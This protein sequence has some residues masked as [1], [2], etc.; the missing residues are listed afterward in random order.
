MIVCQKRRI[1]DRVR[2]VQGLDR[3]KEGT[4][5][6]KRL[7]PTDGRGIPQLGKGHYNPIHYHDVAVRLDDG[8]LTVENRLNL[9]RLTYLADE[10]HAYP[11]GGM[12][13]C[14][15]AVF[16][17]GMLRRVWGGIPDTFFSIPAHAMVRGDYV[18]GF[19]TQ[20]DGVWHFNTFKGATK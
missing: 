15:L 4:V 3:D 12:S 2:I 11:H 18:R 14:G 9:K 20:K 17:D 8:S 16:P 7:I 10:S 13:R 5:V 6:S 1:G 19:L